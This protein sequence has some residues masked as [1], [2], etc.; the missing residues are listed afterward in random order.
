MLR[1]LPG[2]NMVH[3]HKEDEFFQLIEG[4]MFKDLDQAEARQFGFDNVLDCFVKGNLEF[5]R[6]YTVQVGDTILVAIMLERCGNLTYFVTKDFDKKYTRQVIKEVRSLADYT[7]YGAGAI[8]VRTAKFYDQAI[9]FVRLTGFVI[10]ELR[11]DDILWVHHGR[12]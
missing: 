8:F 5:S 2:D 10:R 12:G 4:L 11:Y 7:V 6:Y 1:K 3:I 9:R